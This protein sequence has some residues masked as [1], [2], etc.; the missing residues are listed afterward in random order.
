M[1]MVSIGYACLRV[2]VV[3]SPVSSALNKSHVKWSYNCKSD[4]LKLECFEE[5][6]MGRECIE[7][8]YRL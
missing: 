5:Y 3:L 7:L 1:K 8:H 4:Y 2:E 6:I